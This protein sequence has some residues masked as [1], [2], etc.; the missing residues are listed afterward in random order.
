M[1]ATT[2]GV[3]NSV[4]TLI[5][6]ISESVIFEDSYGPDLSICRRDIC[7]WSCKQWRYM[8]I[9]NALVAGSLLVDVCQMEV[10]YVCIGMNNGCGPEDVRRMHVV[11][12]R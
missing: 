10:E 1:S 9:R 6:S 4:L 11:G 3:G 12:T 7:T 2:E 8:N 5:Q